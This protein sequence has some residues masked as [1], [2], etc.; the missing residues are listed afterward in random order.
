MLCRVLVSTTKGTLKPASIYVA[1]P[2]RG[3]RFAS[4]SGTELHI[5]SSFR[6]GPRGDLRHFTSVRCL[7][8]ALRE[9]RAGRL[10]PSRWILQAPLARRSRSKRDDKRD[11]KFPRSIPHRSRP[12]SFPRPPALGRRT[13]SCLAALRFPTV[14]RPDISPRV[15]A[16]VNLY[17]PGPSSTSAIFGAIAKEPSAVLESLTSERSE[18]E[19]PADR[20]GSLEFRSCSRPDRASET[21]AATAAAPDSGRVADPADPACFDHHPA[22]AGLCCLDPW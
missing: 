1:H 16:N 14:T 17:E 19:N 13:T 15:E 18:K 12:D 6:K 4:R 10:S 3:V 8:P 9:D 20:R 21:A 22:G 7:D 11:R 2:P 5:A